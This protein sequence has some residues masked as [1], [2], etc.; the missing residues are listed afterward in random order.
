MSLEIRYGRDGTPRKH[1]YGRFS[2]DGRTQVVNL[3]VPMRGAPPANLR[4]MG[5]VRF[6]LSR[7]EAEK[8]LERLRADADR[9]GHAQHLTER[10]I[11]IKTGKA[12][13]HVRI[14]EIAARWLAM[15][16]PKTPA[17]TYQAGVRSAC[18]LFKTCMADRNPEAVY[19]YQV[20][21]ADAGAYAELLRGRFAPK[22]VKDY[23]GVVRRS[24]ALFLPT[25]HHNPFALLVGRRASGA[26]EMIHR[27]PFSPEELTRLL[28]TARADAFLYPLIVTAACSGMRRGDVCNLQWSAVDL[29]AGMLAVKTSKTGAEVEI[30][31]FD[32]LR[33]VLDAQKGGHRQWVFPEANEMLRQNPGGLTWRFKKLVA[34]ALGATEV[35]PA[36]APPPAAEV[37]EAGQ[38][39][40]RRRVPAGSRQNRMLDHLRRYCNGASLVA[41]A[42]DTNR[43]KATVSTDLHTIE[44]WIGKPLLRVQPASAKGLIRASTQVKRLT[45]GRA[46]SVRDWHALRATF[47]T[48]ALSA[49]VPV[50]LVRRVTGHATV[51]V[52]LKHYFHPGRDALRAA[53]A[54]AMP[55]VLTVGRGA[56][57]IAPQPPPTEAAP[58]DEL[59]ALAAKVAAGTA[60]ERDRT[61]FRELVAGI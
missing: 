53:L 54:N 33:E 5:D 51:E 55:K 30:P 44:L 22:T 14:D 58:Q 49:G 13:E 9:K 36:P 2:A 10:L 21:S 34:D 37:L 39:A 17:A 59:V 52:V 29:D 46:A 3:G 56:P 24:F 1:W 8:E 18:E 57:T 6:E 40:I 42:R 7:K 35:A 27:K 47:V 4:D 11:E 26:G 45:T 19:L 20:T 32:P 38:A 48:L 16:R 50:E 41:I 25:G 43:S 61:R 12:I 28:D 31:I 15:P 23:C 60:T